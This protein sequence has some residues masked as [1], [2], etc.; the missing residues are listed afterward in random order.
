MAT[1]SGSKPARP[2]RDNTNYGHWLAPSGLTTEPRACFSEPIS[3]PL[4]ADPTF[5]S[6]ADGVSLSVSNHYPQ[7]YLGYSLQPS[8]GHQYEQFNTLGT[9]RVSDFNCIQP[10]TDG[11]ITDMHCAPYNNFQHTM[12]Y[13]APRQFPGHSL[14]PHPMFEAGHYICQ[15]EGCSKTCKRKN[16]MNRKEPFHSCFILATPANIYANESIWSGHMNQHG[17]PLFW[18]PVGGCKRQERANGFHRKDKW[19]EHMKK[20]HGISL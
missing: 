17:P 4:I 9:I 19:L 18:C 12:E 6:L 11:Q 5:C 7:P 16:D 14:G 10:H 2:S 15:I 13:H 3:Q 1:F 8:N 20:R